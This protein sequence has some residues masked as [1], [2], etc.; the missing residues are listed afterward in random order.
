MCFVK[1][2]SQKFTLVWKFYLYLRQ[3]FYVSFWVNFLMSSVKE[4]VY[5][6]HVTI[7]YHMT[8]ILVILNKL[9]VLHT[10]MS[11]LIML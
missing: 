10:S 6:Y 7:I 1:T 3:R 5:V 2:S 4:V 11:G 9:V 8:I